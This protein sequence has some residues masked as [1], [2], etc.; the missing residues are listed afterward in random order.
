MQT[1][2][3]SPSFKITLHQLQQIQTTD[4]STK[5]P[6]KKN[7]HYSRPKSKRSLQKIEIPSAES[8]TT[9]KWAFAPITS[10]K[11]MT[12]RRRPLIFNRRAAV[13]VTSTCNYR[14]GD[15]IQLKWLKCPA[16]L[17]WVVAQCR[18]VLAGVVLGF[19][20]WRFEVRFWFGFRF[21][22]FRWIENYIESW[23]FW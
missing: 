22:W 21:L 20:A 17:C 13:R 2:I 7:R 10:P 19:G 23:W 5:Q 11:S 1:Y 16:M 3:H 8:L 15:P 6:P 14:D 9:T 4:P 18:M 12:A